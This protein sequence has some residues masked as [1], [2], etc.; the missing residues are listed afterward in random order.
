MQW[1]S[2]SN[3]SA[4][5]G[6]GA[7]QRFTLCAENTGSGLTSCKEM[8]LDSQDFEHIEDCNTWDQV[9]CPSPCIGYKC[10][11]FAACV[12]TSDNL[13]PSTACECQLGRIKNEIGDEV[14]LGALVF[15]CRM[16]SFIP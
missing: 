7:R 11:D 9:K 15:K 14:M 13:D 16:Y 10:M 5:C 8:G 4:T 12:D 1:S 6:R 2:W 3:C